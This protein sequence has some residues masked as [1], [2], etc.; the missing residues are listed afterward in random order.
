MTNGEVNYFAAAPGADATRLMK[1][2]ISMWQGR[3]VIRST[4]FTVTA[5]CHSIRV[6]T[7]YRYDPATAML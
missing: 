3:A 5:S 6:E 1:Q 4:L 2:T 7:E